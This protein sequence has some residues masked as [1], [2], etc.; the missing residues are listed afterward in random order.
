MRPAYTCSVSSIPAP[1]SHAVH[2]RSSAESTVFV[3]GSQSFIQTIDSHMS[4]L[5]CWLHWSGQGNV[6]EIWTS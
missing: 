5:V 6:L 1:S 4:T 3:K 2:R